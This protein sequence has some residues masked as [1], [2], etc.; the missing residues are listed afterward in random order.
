MVALVGLDGSR[1]L[2]CIAPIAVGV[3][4][5]AIGVLLFKAIKKEDCL[6]L[7]KGEKIA[8]MLHL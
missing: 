8:N 1:L 2:L 4:V 5:Y 6:L 7:P 3:L